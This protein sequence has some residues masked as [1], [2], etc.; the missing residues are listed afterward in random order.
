M[1]EKNSEK[2]WILI[3]RSSSDG[4]HEHTLQP[5]SN[6]LGRKLDNDVFLQDNAASSYH[7]EFHYDQ[8]T[9]SV[10]IRDLNSTNG[11]FVNGKRIREPQVLQN[12]DQIRI[13]FCLITIVNSVSRVEHTNNLHFSK[14]Q[15]TSDL[16]LESIDHY[17]VLLHEVGQ[18]LVNLPDLDSALTEITELINL[19][20]GSEECLVIMADQFDRLNEMG[21]PTMFA[22]KIIQNK[23][24]TI[25]SN[26]HGASHNREEERTIPVQSMLPV[27]LVP[28]LIDE[29][30]VALIYA[31]KSV[32]STTHFYNSDLHFV[33]AISNQVAMSIQRSRVEGKLIHNSYHDSLTDLPNRAFFLNRLTRSIARSKREDG[34]EFAVLFFD[35]DNFKVV[36]DSLGHTTGDKLLIAIAERLK[37]N[38]RDID[39]VARNTVIA[40]FGGDEFAILLE[41]VKEGR[42]AMATAQ[43]L[44]EILSRPFNIQGKEIYTSV[45]IGVSVSTISYEH[46]EDILQDADIAM[47]HAKALGK[48]R[49]EIYDKTM[50]DRVSEQMR[51]ETAIRQ[52][53]LQNEFQ[54]HYQPIVSLQTGRIAGF[55]ALVRWYTHDRGILLPADFME[56]INTTGLIYSTDHWVLRNA[57]QQA[58][59]WDQSF[60]GIPPLFISVNLSPI[61]IKHPNLVD[62]ISQVLQETELDASRLCLEIT[63]KVSAPDDREAIAVLKQ[64]R[65]L[66]IRISLDDFGTGY[67][68]LS[69]LALFPVDVLKID[70][71]FVHMIGTNGDSKRIIETIKALANHLNLKVI[72]EGVEKADQIPFL[73]STNCEY[74]QGYFYGMPLDSQAATELLKKNLSKVNI[75]EAKMKYQALS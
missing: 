37:H 38:V 66:G 52:G 59:E 19:M 31:R 54:L 39:I 61:N 14:T 27:L 2:K 8:V 40:R 13:G 67:S 72:A 17:G 45:S 11:T 33:L 56:A 5:G 9:D 44:R 74:A 18:R 43:R 35:I 15:V 48:S 47:Y 1:G 70:R 64:L 34:F 29:N 30:V 12:E 58:V 49:V 60:P 46:P 75:S 53:A 16:I 7:A 63:E 28:V 32:E 50:R 41:D 57:C 36:N 71:S 20:I 4:F 10:V 42:H 6:T 73:R 62:N 23:T 68:A 55:E 21:I 26:A 3:I 65:S 69:Y 24:A 51:M 22:Q 25:F